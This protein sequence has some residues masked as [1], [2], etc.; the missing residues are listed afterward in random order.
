M[1]GVLLRENEGEAK[2]REGMG[3]KNRG[4][5]REWVRKG[6]VE[7]REGMRRTRRK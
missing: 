7:G 2:G 3:W 6:W 4:K 5:K 1:R